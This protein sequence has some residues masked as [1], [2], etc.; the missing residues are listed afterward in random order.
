MCR[1]SDEAEEVEK[2]LL[3]VEHTLCKQGRGD[4]AIKCPLYDGCAYQAQKRI[5]ADIW[6]A[7]HECIVHKKPKAL[8]KIGL[9]LIDESPLD[10]FIFGIN[11]PIVELALDALKE[12]PSKLIQGKSGDLSVE[13]LWGA[14]AVLHGILDDIPLPDNPHHGAPVPRTLLLEN[15]VLPH[16][17]V[18]PD[19]SEHKQKRPTIM[20]A[21]KMYRLE[22]RGKVAPK[23]TPDMSKQEVRRRLRGAEGNAVVK[24][25]ATL[26]RLIEQAKHE[27]AEVCGRIQIFRSENGS[28]RMIRMFGLQRI[29]KG[30]NATTLISDATG[31]PELLQPVWPHLECDLTPWPRMPRPHTTVYQIVDRSIAKW[32]IALDNVAEDKLVEKQRAARRMYAAVLLSALQ[33]DGKPVA[34]IIYKSTAEWIRQN[35]F[36]PPWLTLTHHGAITGTNNFENYR[37]LFIVGRLLPQAEIITRQAEALV[38]AHIPER[39][40]VEVEHGGKIPIV[41]DAERHNAVKVNVWR[42]PNAMA[43]RLRRQVTECGLLQA[44]GRGR[45]SQ[46]TADN[47]LDVHLWTDVPVPEIGPSIPQ[48]W[49]EV[50]A[51]LDAVQLASGGVVLESP[52]EGELAYKAVVEAESML[53]GEALKKD[54]AR[55][56]SGHSLYDI[57][58]GDVP[59]L[60]LLRRAVY[61][62]AGSGRSPGRALFLTD[63]ADP[64]AWLEERLG[65][66]S[67]FELD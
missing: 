23:I 14:R 46:R 13:D 3:N 52:A 29:A 1:R 34:I 33:Y 64:R 37:A 35:C 22:W 24:A 39:E 2:A 15:E 59:N 41:P 4:A 48:L 38:G 60:P 67:R 45:A 51:D 40:Y 49:D 19:G 44:F 31:D 61:Q 16:Y 54:R 18:S 42:H 28:G 50:A 26:W 47:P 58:I 36:V 43:E 62:R 20:D 17:I 63:I 6:F 9:V 32:A 53:K 65:P 27:D 10:A 25:R 57:N 30:W 5:K 56:G 21:R 66:L 55:R 7:A 12:P 11:Q 8:G